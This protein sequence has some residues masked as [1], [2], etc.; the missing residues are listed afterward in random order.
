[1][2]EVGKS[3]QKT[4]EEVA[5]QSKQK[6]READ[7]TSPDFLFPEMTE[8]SAESVE[9]ETPVLDY[10]EMIDRVAKHDYDR[11]KSIDW[12]RENSEEMT[13]VIQFTYALSSMIQQE[14][15]F[16]NY[17]N[18]LKQMTGVYDEA[19]AACNRYLE[20]KDPKTARGKA[21]YELV[22][23]LLD[24]LYEDKNMM[25]FNAEVVKKQH[26]DGDAP[27]TWG[28][29][30]TEAH[31]QTLV[32]KQDGVEMEDSKKLVS[33]SSQLLVYKENGQKY[34][35]K[36]SDVN[37]ELDH[38]AMIAHI[39]AG[40]QAELKELLG[41]DDSLLDA[42]TKEEKK[43]RIQY[44]TN[45]LKVLKD[46][47]PIMMKR[48]IQGNPTDVSSSTLRVNKEHTNKYTEDEKKLFIEIYDDF[49]KLNTKTVAAKIAGIAPGEEI[50][51]RNVATS[52]MA[53]LFGV[54][55]I[56]MKSEQA[57]LT[58]NGKSV[59]G[60]RMDEVKGVNIEE[61]YSSA[62]VLGKTASVSSL[63][64][65]QV[66]TLQ[67][68]DIICG[69]IDRNISNFLGQ[70][71]VADGKMEI[72]SICGIDN[73][74]AF[75]CLTYNQILTKQYSIKNSSVSSSLKNIEDE[76]HNIRL[77]GLD[78][79]FAETILGITPSMIDTALGG[80]LN[81]AERNACKDR[82][83]GVQQVIL[84]MQKLDKEAKESDPPKD[85]LL[86][87]TDE[88]WDQLKD[89]LF[90]V[91]EKDKRDM[92]QK[93]YLFQDLFGKKMNE[94]VSYGK[95]NAFRKE[96]RFNIYSEVNT[97]PEKLEKEDYHG[98]SQSIEAIRANYSDYLPEENELLEEFEKA[99]NSLDKPAM[100][101][102]IE[103]MLKESKKYPYVPH[104]D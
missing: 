88:E 58:V 15:D 84:N 81:E 103:K 8:A 92:A 10:S 49:R 91:E 21:R 66:L 33:T 69:Q 40:Y 64:L 50:S 87:E 95:W 25:E 38:K 12:K 63:A 7:I 29:I 85:P 73:D 4:V 78:K 89:R 31:R 54:S 55:D 16:S 93:T 102:V 77:L 61:K 76:D 22:H 14:V 5:F 9:I 104:L 82:L 34:F 28:S 52:V 27:V 68:F 17:D 83:K 37:V 57:K 30:V 71:E 53:D 70:V 80:L 39:G 75:G 97:M 51:K 59:D 67:V 98:L 26:H 11:K 13:E 65:K 43:Q 46:M 36:G 20:K 45:K 72:K 3:K 62:E 48:D 47:I 100:K 44:L 18:D 2:S 94:F 79:K 1:M 35:F 90:A 19:I 41:T 96:L 32:D 6:T 56:I 101:A 42:E 99:L 24:H 74:T 60:L 23:R 86:L